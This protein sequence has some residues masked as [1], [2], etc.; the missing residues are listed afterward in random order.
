PHPR[1]TLFRARRE[2]TRVSWR[3]ILQGRTN[4]STESIEGGPPSPLRGGAH[5]RFD[6][7][8]AALF[9]LADQPIAR[10]LLGSEHAPVTLRNRLTLDA[11]FDAIAGEDFGALL[12]ERRSE[13]GLIF[14][15]QQHCDSR[16]CP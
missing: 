1:T 9:G 15:S 10:L 2:R 4:H 13:L 5:L 16:F 11:T 12:L 8:K 7:V 6:V 3:I 14:R